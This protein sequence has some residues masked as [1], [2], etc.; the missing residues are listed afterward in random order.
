MRTTEER[1]GETKRSGTVCVEIKTSGRAIGRSNGAKNSSFLE[2]GL[3]SFCWNDVNQV[4][5]GWDF[6]FLRFRKIILM[7]TQRAIYP[8]AP[9]RMQPHRPRP[10]IFARIT[11]RRHSTIGHASRNPSVDF[12]YRFIRRLTEEAKRPRLRRGDERSRDS[13]KL[14]ESERQC[15]RGPT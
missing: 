1:N 2:T 14:R 8:N 9:T 3:L 6:I 12:E 13:K 15:R 4:T 5:G 10:M 7:N 11:R